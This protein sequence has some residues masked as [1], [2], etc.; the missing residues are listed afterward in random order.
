MSVA[1]PRPRVRGVPGRYRL[2]V[3]AYHRMIAAGIVAEDE[4]VELIEGE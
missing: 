3:D 4:R 2:K 1:A